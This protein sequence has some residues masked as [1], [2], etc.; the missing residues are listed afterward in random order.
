MGD[1][2]ECCDRETYE[3]NEFCDRCI[4][5]ECDDPDCGGW[6]SFDEVEDDE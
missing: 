3:E 1:F 4:D 5:N 6:L 2:C